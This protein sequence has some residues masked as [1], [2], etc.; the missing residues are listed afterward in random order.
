MESNNTKK[1]DK[2]SIYVELDCLLDTRLPLLYMISEKTA[3]RVLYSG[4]YHTRH[5]DQFDCISHD[6][7]TSLYNRRTKI[8]LFMSTKTPMLNVVK[9]HY[10]EIITDL[11][12]IDHEE[13]YTIFL[14]TW[15]Y[16]LQDTEKQSFEYLLKQTIPDCIVKIIDMSPHDLTPT[17]LYDHIGTMVM[18]EPMRW[19]EFHTSTR[20]LITNPLV[21]IQC[22]SPM[23]T[24]S[25]DKDEIYRSLELYKMYIDINF[26]NVSY[27]SIELENVI[28]GI[29]SK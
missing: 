14:N 6:I 16:E 22:Y 28:N 10:G 26:L 5:M 4:Y 25:S 17:W 8:L 2:K 3:E 23:M 9:E 19:L 24:R 20:D 29:N 15:P 12:N 27:F 11:T 18:Y 13:D 1:Q 21:N 7:F